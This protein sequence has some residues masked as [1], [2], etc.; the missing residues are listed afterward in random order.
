M[1]D[2]TQIKLKRTIDR[3]YHR[4]QIGKQIKDL[5]ERAGMSQ[6]DLS[7]QADL[8]LGNIRSIEEG[9]WEL[10]LVSLCQLSIALN[11]PIIIDAR[12]H[13]EDFVEDTE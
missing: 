1:I 4:K 8:A 5:R 7:R 3:I 11:A 6:Y 9:R 10:R 2:L 12:G 13:D